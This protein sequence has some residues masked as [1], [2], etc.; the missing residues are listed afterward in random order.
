MYI[1]YKVYF[2]STRHLA[3]KDYKFHKFHELWR[4]K[5]DA[6]FYEQ[7]QNKYSKFSVVEGNI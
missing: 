4:G 1:V 6:E 7:K 3:G 5:L 2:N